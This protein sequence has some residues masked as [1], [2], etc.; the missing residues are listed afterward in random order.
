MNQNDLLILEADA[1]SKTFGKTRVLDSLDLHVPKGHIVE[2]R[3]SNGSGKTTLLSILSSLTEPDSGMVML[4]G[5]NIK[6]LGSIYRRCIGTVFHV[7][8]IYYQLTIKE[9]LEYFGKLYRLTNVSDVVEE[10]VDRLNL[11]HWLDQKVGTLSNGLKKRVSIA[12]SMLHSPQMLLLDEPDT[13]LD[14]ATLKILGDVFDE[15]SG[16][17]GA[18]LLTTHTS[19]IKYL[20]PRSRYFLVDGKLCNELSSRD[21]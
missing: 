1:I 11:G 18:I 7:P 14:E 2:I 20:A 3:G 19:S 4:N 15:F 13:G 21:A 8:L 6:N 12:K 5:S 9:N 17:G 10:K 16:D